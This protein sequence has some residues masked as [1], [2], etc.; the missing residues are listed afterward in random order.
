MSRRVAFLLFGLPLLGLLAWAHRQTPPE[1]VYAHLRQDEQ[2]PWIP[3]SSSHDF[4]FEFE[5]PAS[6]IRGI[7][8]QHLF[9]DPEADVLIQI[10]NRTQTALLLR[11]HVGQGHQHWASIP[12]SNARGDR[13]AVTYR[14][15]RS[16]QDQ[17]PAIVQA[18]KR[19]ALPPR[20][21]VSILSGGLSPSGGPVYP[22]FELRYDYP[23]RYLLV[24]WPLVLVAGFVLYR[25][26][27]HQPQRLGLLG[28]IAI[29]STATSYLA[30]TQ[31][32]EADPGRFDPR[33]HLGYATALSQWLSSPS[34][35]PQLTAWFSQHHWVHFPLA[36]ALAAISSRLGPSVA[37]AYLGI[38]GLSSFAALLLADFYLVTYLQVRRRTAVL[39]LLLFG[40]NLIS[41]LGFVVLSPATLLS[42]L[43]IGLCCALA[44]RAHRAFPWH[45]EL[46][47]GAGILALALCYPPG[48]WGGLWLVAMAITLDIVRT[49]SFSLTG[50]GRALEFYL[51]P[52]AAL[53]ALLALGFNWAHSAAM[54]RSDLQAGQHLSTWGR[55]ITP[56]LVSV[57]ALLLAAPG[58]RLRDGRRVALLVPLGWTV[59]FFIER[60]RSLEPFALQSFLPALPGL[61]LLAAAGLQRLDTQ[62]PRLALISVF[63]LSS[64][65]LWVAFL[66]LDPTQSQTAWLLRLLAW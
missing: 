55:W 61:H 58:L 23:I 48:L 28:L 50:Q 57:Q 65:N 59:F 31:A 47:F 38:S 6:R 49:R 1:P 32:Y 27:A 19:S 51:F 25:R 30:W 24:L 4:V 11:E 53:F 36:P 12:S 52:P 17:F 40:S 9:T 14:V 3:L 54:L 43:G 39:A 56:F 21:P 44:L 35:R 13:M 42:A 63:L 18:V 10:E 20:Y 37:V 60:A 8:L 29:A 15:L 66:H 26:D 7:S 34:A 22:L 5:A 33:Q 45:A 46:A 16:R 62:K 2:S 64:L 41:I